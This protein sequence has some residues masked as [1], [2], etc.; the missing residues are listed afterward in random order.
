VAWSDMEVKLQWD[1]C[2]Y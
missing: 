2:L 1:L